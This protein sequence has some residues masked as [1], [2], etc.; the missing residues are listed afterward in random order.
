MAQE[1]QKQRLSKLLRELQGDLGLRAFSRKIGINYA[2]LTAYMFG[3]SFPES[4][5]L[6]KVAVAKGWTLEEIEAYLDDRPVEPEKPIKEVLKEIRIMSAQDA[7]RAATEALNRLAQLAGA[8]DS[9]R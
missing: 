6:T 7:K 2:S 4:K 5:N 3:D 8:H 9:E 1:Q